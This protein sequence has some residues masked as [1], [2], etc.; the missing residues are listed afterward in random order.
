MK[1]TIASVL[2]VL[3]AS[4]CSNHQ[5]GSSVKDDCTDI[6]GDNPCVPTPAEDISDERAIERAN[7]AL[8]IG[9]VDEVYGTPSRGKTFKGDFSATTILASTKTANG[10]RG[11]FRIHAIFTDAGAGYAC[12]AIVQMDSA[13]AVAEPKPVDGHAKFCS[14]L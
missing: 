11:M 5:A 7:G 6:D 12:E 9:A 13:G 2:M 14:Q 10:Q 4:A 8:L 3:L 1:N